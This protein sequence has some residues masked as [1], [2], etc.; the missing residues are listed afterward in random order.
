M[1]LPQDSGPARQLCIA[2][3]R[4]L[5]LI[6]R[7]SVPSIDCVCIYRAIHLPTYLRTCQ[8]ALMH[9]LIQLHVDRLREA[10]I[11]RRMCVFTL[12]QRRYREINCAYMYMCDEDFSV[13]FSGWSRGWGGQAKAKEKSSM[14]ASRISLHEMETMAG[15]V[16]RWLV[17]SLSE[18]TA[19]TK[20]T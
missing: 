10:L 15:L 13:V 3:A 7:S 9:K 8:W 2:F 16:V 19:A 1:N 6:P 11:L 20:P 12:P 5:P 4:Q 18:R 14:V 17:V